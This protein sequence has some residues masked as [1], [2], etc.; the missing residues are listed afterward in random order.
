MENKYQ[1]H[2]AL[3]FQLFCLFLNFKMYENLSKLYRKLIS[4]Q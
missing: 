3:D 2:P 1:Y 4:E